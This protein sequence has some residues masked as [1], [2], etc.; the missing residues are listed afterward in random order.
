VPILYP[1]LQTKIS[2]KMIIVVKAKNEKNVINCLSNMQISALM[3]QGQFWP[4]VTNVS[5]CA[6]ITAMAMAS[7]AESSVQNAKTKKNSSRKVVAFG[8]QI[9]DITAT[10]ANFN[11]ALTAQNAR[12]R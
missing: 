4:A 8:C 10:G 2:K 1:L 6:G 5:M 7:T 3:R 12:I 9:A 11:A